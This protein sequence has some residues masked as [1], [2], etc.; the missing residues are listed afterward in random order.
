[1]SVVATVTTGLTSRQEVPKPKG[2]VKRAR[3]TFT[4]TVTNSG[5]TGKMAWRL[6]FSRL[7]G[8][9]VAAH[10]HVGQRGKAGPVAVALCGPCRSGMRRSA[11]LNP[12]T[13]AA[14]QTGRAYVN[15]HTARNPA[16][17]VRGQIAAVALR[18]T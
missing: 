9:A 11:D 1:V 18:I 16:G 6:S 17:E 5:T 14:L 4:A 10:I 15:V 12:A 7:T 8:R 13:L 2:N 3:A